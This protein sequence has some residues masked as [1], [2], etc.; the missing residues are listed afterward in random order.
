MQR[1]RTQI[2][3]TEAVGDDGSVR[4]HHTPA[5][6]KASDHVDAAVAH[7]Y[8]YDIRNIESGAK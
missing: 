3:V 6:N 8:N 4:N 2:L 7:D 5:N 1:F